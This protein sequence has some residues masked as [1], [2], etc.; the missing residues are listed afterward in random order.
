[1]LKLFNHVMAVALQVFPPKATLQHHNIPL[2][3]VREICLY[4]L[5]LKEENMSRYVGI[6]SD[7][8]LVLVVLVRVTGWKQNSCCALHTDAAT[9]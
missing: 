4:F 7:S 5:H 1:M 9:M 8:N 6:I 2:T 3:N